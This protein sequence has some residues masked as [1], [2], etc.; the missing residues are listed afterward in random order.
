M[1][2]RMAEV[3]RR[4]VSVL[5]PLLVVSSVALLALL[6]FNLRMLDPGAEELP[7]VPVAEPTPDVAVAEGT[8]VPLRILYVASI[9]AIATLIVVGTIYLLF[10]GVKVWQLFNRWEFV[11]YAL[12]VTVLVALFLF[13]D[14]INAW[15]QSFLHTISGLLGSGSGSGEP[16]EP[17]PT[18]TGGSP[19][20]VLVLLVATAYLLVFAFIFF[21]RFYRTVAYEEPASGGGRR[22]LARAVQ[23]A[24]ADLQAGEEFRVA[25]LRCYKTMV[26]LFEGHGTE[27]RPSQTA[28]EFE[29]EALHAWGVPVESVDGL[30]SL[31]EE[32]RYSQ[33][34][35]GERQRDAAIECLASIRRDLESGA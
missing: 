4:T 12:A 7:E 3:G 17:L 24:I 10:R 5:A 35:I 29:E 6:A 30:T 19:V 21:R 13:W 33:H 11:G 8:G 26:L 27:Q 1:N 32:A 16:P 28:R 14:D 25:V 20:M 15:F 23:T 18:G 9:L 2:G 34:A 31:F 22:A